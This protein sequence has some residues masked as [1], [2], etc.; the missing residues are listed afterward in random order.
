MKK[1]HQ[2]RSCP[3]ACWPAADQQLWMDACAGVGLLGEENPAFSWSPR[4]RQMIET[5]YGRYIAWIAVTTHAVQLPPADRIQPAA[6]TAFIEDLENECLSGMSIANYVRSIRAFA[7][8][9]AP[10][11]DWQWLARKAFR[12]KAR[13]VPR[14]DKRLRVVNSRHLFDLGLELMDSSTSKATESAA[15][16]QFR[17]GLMVALL[18][19]RPIRVG[20]FSRLEL[21]RTLVYR[22]PEYWLC[23]SEQETK[24]GRPINM[25]L[26]D[27]LHVRIDQFLRGPRKCLLQGRTHGGTTTALWLS[28]K[29]EPLKPDQIRAIINRRTKSAFGHR[30]NPHLFRDCLAT[31]LATDDPEHVLCAVPILGHTNFRMMEK[32]YNQATMGTATR[33][34]ASTLMELRND[35]IGQFGLEAPRAFLVALERRQ[36]ITP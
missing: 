28:A 17:D 2:A 23:Y 31:T 22:R 3:A 25:P 36:G 15:A 32:H 8:A 35:L 13:A 10:D 12:L 19:A 1:L 33:K 4:W 6:I 26:P 16:L 14:T 18:A 7:G 34:F 21:N 30:V 24:T 11:R 29:G 5:A 9:I 20:N 27:Q